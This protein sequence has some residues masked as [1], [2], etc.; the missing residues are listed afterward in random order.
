MVIVQR[1]RKRNDGEEQ[2]GPPC[3]PDTGPPYLLGRL[4]FT[5]T[6]MTSQP[7]LL[8]MGVPVSSSCRSRLVAVM[9]WT[10]WISMFPPVKLEDQTSRQASRRCCY[11]C[12]WGYYPYLFCPQPQHLRMER[13]GSN[14]TLHDENIGWGLLTVPQPAFP[15]PS[16]FEEL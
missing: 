4:V 14:L 1:I 10:T 8:N 6:R 5:L 16:Y 3:F 7:S 9:F 15:L 13:A 2:H 11:L 12:Y